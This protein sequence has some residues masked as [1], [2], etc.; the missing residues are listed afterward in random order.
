M[1]ST[2]HP[3]R[4]EHP[5]GKMYNDAYAVAHHLR[6]DK[7]QQMVRPTTAL[8]RWPTL[9]VYTEVCKNRKVKSEKP[10]DRPVHGIQ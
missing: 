10:R 9:K 7:G 8:G 1:Q 3:D 6:Q 2:A 5:K 4:Q